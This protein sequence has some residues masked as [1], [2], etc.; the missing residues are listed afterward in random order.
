[1]TLAARNTIFVVGV[2]VTFFLLIVY[3]FAGYSL[4]F[5]RYSNAVVA[6]GEQ[7]LQPAPDGGAKLGGARRLPV[8]QEREQGKPGDARLAVAPGAVG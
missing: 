6:V 1:M 3:A 2:I 8:R 5:G 7:P 4:L